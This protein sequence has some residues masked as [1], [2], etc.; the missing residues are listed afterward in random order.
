M[1][2]GTGIPFSV[3]VSQQVGLPGEISVAAPAETTDR[4]V[5]VDAHAPHLVDADAASERFAANDVVTPLPECLPS[6]QPHL[7]GRS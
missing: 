2:T 6:H 1:G 5:P 7:R 4:A 3:E